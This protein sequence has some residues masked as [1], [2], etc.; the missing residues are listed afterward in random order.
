MGLNR[1]TCT[2]NLSL[3][4]INCGKDILV[5]PETGENILSLFAYCHFLAL[6]ENVENLLSGIISDC[7]E[8]QRSKDSLLAVYLC[9]DDFLLL[10]NLKLQPV[11]SVWNDS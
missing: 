7:P 1:I 2:E 4:S 11:S 10:I 6:V 9:D 5:K 3:L 8:E